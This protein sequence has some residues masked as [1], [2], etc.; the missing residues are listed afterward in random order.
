[1]TAHHFLCNDCLV[2]CG[3]Q[4]QLRGVHEV[5][6]AD[7]VED[8]LPTL[9]R[10]ARCQLSCRTGNTPIGTDVSNCLDTAL[11]DKLLPQQSV[12]HR[13]RHNRDHAAD[14]WRCM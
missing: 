6:A 10:R 2:C 4:L 7:V 1:M 12:L 5:E 13:R 8:G 11:P 14:I 3:G 9:R